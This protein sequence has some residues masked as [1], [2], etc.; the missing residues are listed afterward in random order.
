[1]FNEELIKNTKN[2]R[3]AAYLGIKLVEVQPGYAVA[4]MEI[5]ENHLNGVGLVHGGALFSLADYAFSVASNS[6]GPLSLATSAHISYFKPPQGKKVI[7]R[8]REITSSK[9]LGHY[10]VDILDEDETL[11]G[12]FTGSVYIKKNKDA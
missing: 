5:T 11:I 8:A 6:K 9:K 1:M 7:A 3:F 4:E 2:D 10:Q 12:R